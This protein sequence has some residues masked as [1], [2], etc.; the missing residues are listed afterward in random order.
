MLKHLSSLHTPE[1]LHALASMGHGD[2]I[3]LVDAHF[4]AASKAARLVRLDG[5]DLVAVLD[6]CLQL[7]PLD[8]FVPE[9]AVAMA[10]VGAAADIPDVQRDCQSVIDRHE[11]RATPLARIDRHEFY[12]RAAQAFAIVATGEQRPYGCLLLT[13][14]VCVPVDPGR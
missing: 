8:G 4:P 13:K 14:G 11:G 9:P 1:L 2:E 3:A 7:I 5:A 10:V 6:A 12:R